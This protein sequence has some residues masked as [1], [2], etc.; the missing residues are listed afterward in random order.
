MCMDCPF[1][2]V[3]SGLIVAL[4]MNTA[5]AGAT[6]RLCYSSKHHLFDFVSSA[7]NFL[8]HRKRRSGGHNVVG[9][10]GFKFVSFC[11]TSPRG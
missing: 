5:A 1:I 4:I 10:G 3:I 9:T 2:F 8:K 11:L 6:V 7:H